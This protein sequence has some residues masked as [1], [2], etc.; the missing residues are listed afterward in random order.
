MTALL[1]IEG[2]VAG[3]GRGDI[4][5]G[6]DLELEQGS[7][8]CL[9]GPN[10]AGKST[11]L[12]ALSGLLRPR[13]GTIT[14]DG[15]EISRRSPA[16]LLARGI[17]HVAQERSLFPLMT[18]WDNLLMGGHV[19]RDRLLVR[20]RADAIAE[21]FELVRERRDERAGELSGGQQKLVEIARALMLEPRLIL[22]DEPTMG[23]DPRARHLMFETVGELN[24]EGRTVL[25]VEQNARAGLAIAHHGA[26]L[27]SGKV[28]LTG[29]GATLLDDPRVAELY[30]GGAPA[31][32]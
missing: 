1:K 12:K 23:L 22:M 20:T 26:V 15:E 16:E 6:I 27:D 28:A 25:L 10:G 9:V 24:A 11:V 5:R 21:R 2:I 17:V 31:A 14:L 13:A 19:L 30:L 29:P 18:V 7:I 8:T 32:A 4:L 3:Y